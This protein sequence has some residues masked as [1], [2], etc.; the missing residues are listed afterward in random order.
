MMDMD[1]FWSSLRDG[2]VTEKKQKNKTLI[3][4]KK[5]IQKQPI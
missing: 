5:K 2:T 1:S 3:Q 4:K